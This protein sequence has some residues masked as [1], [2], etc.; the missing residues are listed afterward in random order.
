MASEIGGYLL[1][2]LTGTFY[3]GTASPVSPEAS[4][5]LMKTSLVRPHGMVGS[6]SATAIGTSCNVAASSYYLPL[7]GR[8][9]NKELLAAARPSTNAFKF[10][11]ANRVVIARVS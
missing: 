8:D 1:E 6:I 11:W 7:L 2:I 5:S 9:W 10:C 3:R 4:Y